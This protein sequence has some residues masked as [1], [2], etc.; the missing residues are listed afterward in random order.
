MSLPPWLEE[1]I[2]KAHDRKAFDCGDEDLNRFLRDHARRNHDQ[3]ASKT[4]LAINANDGRE[5]LGY[6][7][8]SPAAVAFDRAPEVIARGLPRYDVPMFRLGRLAVATAY[9]GKGLLGGRLLLAAGRRC[10][11]VAE[12]VGGVALL[13][14]AKSE[15][16]ARWYASYGA[17]PLPTQPLCLILPLST[18][19]AALERG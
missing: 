11:A 13:I 8:L 5:I 4:F 15:R 1:P 6:Y 16:V 9:Q 14:D 7:S 2:S 10:L 18:I 19:K 17:V 12:Q 3:G